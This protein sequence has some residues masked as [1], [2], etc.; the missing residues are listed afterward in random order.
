MLCV[1]DDWV[2]VKGA[3]EALIPL[4]RNA[5]YNNLEEAV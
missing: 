3:P 1:K 5:K 2:V 4:C